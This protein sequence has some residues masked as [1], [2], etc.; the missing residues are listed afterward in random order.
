M[1]VEMSAWA[2]AILFELVLVNAALVVVFYIRESRVKDGYEHKL[3]EAEEHVQAARAE[4][5]RI[6]E[7]SLRRKQIVIFDESDME[8]LVED[9][10]MI[11]DT[12]AFEGLKKRIFE[13]TSVLGDMGTSTA[14][15]TQRITET[16]EKQMEAVNMVGRLGG[17]K[18]LPPEFK[19]KAEAILDAFRTMDET[20]SVA[21]EEVSKVEA[22][23]NE[24]TAMV[25][26]FKESDPSFRLPS[27]EELNNALRRKSGASDDVVS[28]STPP[29]PPS[30]TFEGPELDDVRL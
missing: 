9:G 1:N 20:L 27:A 6:E 2:V 21:H 17:T 24:V 3:E 28:V 25:A 26:D 30:E 4:A 12:E 29:E 13:S 7:E 16:L 19:E 18:G 10:I 22:G 5:R 15:V 14:E 11:G 8:V 23:I